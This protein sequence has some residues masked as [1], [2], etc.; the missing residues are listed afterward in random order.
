[1][2]ISSGINYCCGRHGRFLVEDTNF[3]SRWF[4]QMFLWGQGFVMDYSARFRCARRSFVYFVGV[5]CCFWDPAYG[6]SRG[7]CGWR[8]N[9]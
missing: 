5:V 3:D 6:G 8:R 9:G 7:V 2:V 4:S 1:M